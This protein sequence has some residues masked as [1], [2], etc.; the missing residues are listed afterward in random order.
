MLLRLQNGSLPITYVHM[1][2]CMYCMYVYIYI[3]IHMVLLCAVYIHQ[4]IYRRG[5]Y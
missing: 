3:Y 4:W 5:V 2:V 1:Y